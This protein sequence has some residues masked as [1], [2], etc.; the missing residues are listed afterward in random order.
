[1]GLILKYIRYLFIEFMGSMALALGQTQFRRRFP[2][3]QLSYGTFQLGFFIFPFWVFGTMAFWYRIT[4]AHLN[5]IISIIWILRRDKPHH[6]LNILTGLYI[7]AQY[8]GHFWGIALI[9]W[10]TN[11][12]GSLLIAKNN[13]NW[14]YSDA[15]GQEFVASFTAEMP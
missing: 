7:P 12:P 9:W 11:D 5:P 4:G 6:M 10:Y 14:D 3:P 13:G 15:I 2:I 1:M 8:L